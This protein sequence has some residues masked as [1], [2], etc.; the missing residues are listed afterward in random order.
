MAVAV[1]A[2]A[3][4]LSPRP[5]AAQF[6]LSV[7]RELLAKLLRDGHYKQALAESRRVEEALVGQTAGTPA[8]PGKKGK[9]IKRK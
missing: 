2:T 8:K 9:V 6:D 7:E 1:L 4:V 3:M 5:A